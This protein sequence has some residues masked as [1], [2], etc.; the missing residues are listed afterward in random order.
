[1]CLRALTA[2]AMEKMG[3]AQKTQPNTVRMEKIAENQAENRGH[4]QRPVAGRGN[5]G[6]FER[7][8]NECILDVH[9]RV[10]SCQFSVIGFQWAVGSGQ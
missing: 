6:G 9:G 10:I 1:M 3:M 4:V 7:F 5:L 2:K 8:V